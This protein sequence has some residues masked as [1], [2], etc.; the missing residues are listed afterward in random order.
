MFQI[1]KEHLQHI[2]ELTIE[3][4]RINCD[5]IKS[6]QYNIIILKSPFLKMIEPLVL[7]DNSN[8][9]EVRYMNEIGQILYKKFEGEEYKIIK[10]IIWTDYIIPIIK[11][12]YLL[13]FALPYFRYL[14]RLDMIF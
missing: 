12:Q 6:S 2:Q 1:T 9:I 10:S 5:Y 13:D 11:N 3:M 8:T 4:N 7:R 14:M